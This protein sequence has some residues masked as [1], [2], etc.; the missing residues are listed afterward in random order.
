VS[1][2]GPGPLPLSAHLFWPLGIAA[3][4]G[5]QFIFMVLVADRSIR[6]AHRRVIV[7]VEICT[8]A[9][10]LLSATAAVAIFIMGSGL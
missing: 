4:T 5:G 9:T 7:L 2:E 8:F 6:G 10:F 1:V 3:V